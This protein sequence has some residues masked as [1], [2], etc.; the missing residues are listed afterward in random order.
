MST[1]S[2]AI[3]VFCTAIWSNF[4]D[5]YDTSCGDA[6]DD[7]DAAAVDFGVHVYLFLFRMVLLLAAVII[8]TYKNK[9]KN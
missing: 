2:P 8:P 6:G 3:N 9:H 7:D 4:N 1:P 5:D